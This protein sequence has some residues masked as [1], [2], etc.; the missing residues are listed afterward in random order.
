MEH[1]LWY[2][3]VN[4]MSSAFPIKRYTCIV[5]LGR[6]H[7]HITHLFKTTHFWKVHK[8]VNRDPTWAKILP[9]FFFH[10]DGVLAIQRLTKRWTRICGL[11][12]V[13]IYQGA[14]SCEVWSQR[15]VKQLLVTMQ[16]LSDENKGKA[17]VLTEEKP[18]HTDGPLVVVRTQGYE[19][20]I[21]GRRR[22]NA[23]N[24]DG[25]CTVWIISADP[26]QRLNIR[27]LVPN[28]R[29]SFNVRSR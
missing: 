5:P 24:G 11:S 6:G 25:K 20:L 3:N 28:W 19:F 13:D 18:R 29:T 10:R 15:R 21:D 8:T 14:V 26:V 17:V 1:S 2:F 16:S 22:A 9:L 4:F 23:L 27:F 7:M 12:K